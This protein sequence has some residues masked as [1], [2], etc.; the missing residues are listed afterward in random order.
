MW[1]SQANPFLENKILSQLGLPTSM[2]LGWC[3]TWLVLTKWWCT[4]RNISSSSSSLHKT[5][6]CRL[7]QTYAYLLAC[8]SMSGRLYH[9]LNLRFP[10][11]ASE[12][13]ALYLHSFSVIGLRFLTTAFSNNLDVLLGTSELWWCLR[14]RTTNVAEIGSWVS[15]G[16]ALIWNTGYGTVL[17][18][19]WA[20]RAAFASRLQI[21]D[22]FMILRSSNG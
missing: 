18:N 12:M 21:P 13:E 2:G 11:L 19:D 8:W 10:L 16:K 14:K 3:H 15:P 17:I 22:W 4:G 20:K 1:C 7:L 9:N 5:A 6:P